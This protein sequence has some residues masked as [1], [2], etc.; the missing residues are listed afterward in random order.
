[1]THLLHPHPSSSTEAVL[2]Q[3]KADLTQSDYCTASD[4]DFNW[5]NTLLVFLFGM[6]VNQYYNYS[7]FYQ[8]SNKTQ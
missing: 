6:K 8:Q 3:K 1:M 4:K 5:A 7:V 2:L